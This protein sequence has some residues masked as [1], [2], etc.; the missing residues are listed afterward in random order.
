LVTLSQHFPWFEV[1]DEVDGLVEV[2]AAAMPT[3]ASNAAAAMKP[4]PFIESHLSAE[5]NTHANR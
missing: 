1:E 3:L 2:C 4:I 5:D